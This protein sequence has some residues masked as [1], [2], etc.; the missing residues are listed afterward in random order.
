MKRPYGP[1]GQYADRTVVLSTKQQQRAELV[2]GVLAADEVR[3]NEHERLQSPGHEPTQ[4]DDYSTSA[5][6]PDARPGATSAV[7]GPLPRCPGTVADRRPAPVGLLGASG[8][9]R[10]GP[11]SVDDQT[12]AG[13][14]PIP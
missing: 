13:S 4:R 6:L 3:R 12:R 2:E 10:A 9:R 8:R 11:A 14:A 7:V 1:R 5:L